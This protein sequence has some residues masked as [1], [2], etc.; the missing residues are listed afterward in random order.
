M[1]KEEF[2]K[3]YERLGGDGALEAARDILD[4]FVDYLKECEP[5]AVDDIKLFE[6]ARDELPIDGDFLDE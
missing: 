1:S 3:E 2:K 6:A 4:W 5:Q